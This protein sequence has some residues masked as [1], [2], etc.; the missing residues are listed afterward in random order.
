MFH[1]AQE[2]NFSGGKGIWGEE[3]GGVKKKYI[4]KINITEKKLFALQMRT[5]ALLTFSYVSM[6]KY[7]PVSH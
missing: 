5:E 7:R 1:S 4:K 3:G 6:S 2:Q